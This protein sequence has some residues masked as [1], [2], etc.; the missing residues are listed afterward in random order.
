MQFVFQQHSSYGS[1]TP[2][3][4]RTMLQTSQLSQAYPLNDQQRKD[5][6][7]VS[8]DV[9][10]RLLACLERFDRINGQVLKGKGQA[11]QGGIHVQAG[12]RVATIPAVTE[13]Q[14]DAEAYLSSAKMALRDIARVFKPFYGIAFDHR[15][16]RIRKWIAKKFG[17][18]DPLHHLLIQ[19]A[20]WIERI[21]GMRNAV[22]HPGG[23][24]GTLSVEDFKLVNDG[25]PWQVREPVWYRNGEEPVPVAKEIEA[26]N[27]NLLTLFE[28]LV[29]D[30]L[31]RLAPDA[32]IVIYEIPEA[33]RDPTMP[34]RYRVG[35]KPGFMPREA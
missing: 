4:A 19:D 26:W 34:I 24:D 18:D 35:L 27:H 17:T 29:C 25:P 22:E 10:M 21:V 31:V 3:A 12:G 32:P 7:V 28:D 6:I 30:G 1:S 33:D 13:L 8:H 14:M 20:P 9:M 23:R 5:L 11:E 16:Q 2:A 15:F